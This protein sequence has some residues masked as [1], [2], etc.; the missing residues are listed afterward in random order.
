MDPNSRSELNLTPLHA[1]VTTNRKDR[2]ELLQ[3][4]LIHSRADI[5]L[6]TEDGNTGLHLAVMVNI[7]T[8][9]R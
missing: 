9:I 5:E 4:L 6:C 1:I 7:K 3:A 8:R 2:A